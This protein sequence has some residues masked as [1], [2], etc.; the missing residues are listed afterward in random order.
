MTLFPMVKRESIVQEL[1]V[2]REMQNIAIGTPNKILTKGKVLGDHVFDALEHFCQTHKYNEIGRLF[3]I[4][5]EKVGKGKYTL[6]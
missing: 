5:L 4:A 1:C 3:L 2:N 6:L